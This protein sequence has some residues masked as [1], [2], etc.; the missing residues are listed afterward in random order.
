MECDL[1]LSR[2]LS[3]AIYVTFIPARAPTLISPSPYA[4][5]TKHTPQL[6][7]NASQTIDMADQPP[8]VVP[9]DTFEPAANLDDAEVESLA[10]S[11]VSSTVSLTD[12]IFEYRNLHGRTYQKKKVGEYWAPNDDQQNEGLDLIH[13]FVTMAL[14]G[15]LY[16]APLGDDVQQVL[17]VGTGTGIWATDFGDENPSVEVIGT[18]I[19]AIQPGWTPPN[20][21][22]M[23]DNCL[24]DWTWPENHFDFVHIRSMY[25]SIPDFVE[26]Y[27]KGLRHLKPSGWIQ[28]LEL[29]VLMQSD[30]V[31][32][33]SDHVYSRFADIFH[34][35]GEKMG[36]TFDITKGHNMRDYVEKAGFV[37]IVEKKIKV[38]I[39]GWAKDP[40]LK[41]MGYL[42]LAA[43]DQ[44]LE[45]YALLICTEVLGWT[46]EEAILL[47]AEM[48]REIRKLSNCTWCWM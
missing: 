42:S 14:G 27:K 2:A 45:G 6:R 34:V 32:L 9:E 44:G 26:L 15:K 40:H 22:F 21:R 37:N 20:V 46:R 19:S 35:G 4:T 8:T 38:P 30:H 33:P 13:H 39:H 48:R 16:L 1:S 11:A 18:D 3:S 7:A 24:E 29:D 12:S 41:K 5:T 28:C 36:R 17:D 25:G 31:D 43:L 10:S 47:V 23:I